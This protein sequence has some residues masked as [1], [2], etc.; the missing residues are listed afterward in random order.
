ME[1]ELTQVQRALAVA[2]S[3]RLKAESKREAAHKA[4]CLAGEACTKAKE[5]NSRLTDERLSL[6][7]ELGTIKDDFAAL[8]E[9]VVANR[10]TMEV[11]F[12]A[13]GD[14]LFNYGYGC[15]VFTHNICGRKP[16]IPN[17]MPDPSVLLTPE[18]FANPRC[19]PITSSIAPAP[20][21]ATVSREES[22][23]TARPSPERRR[24][25][26]WVSRLRRTARLRMPL[27]IMTLVLCEAR[28]ELFSVSALKN[29]H[30]F[31]FLHYFLFDASLYVLMLRRLGLYGFLLST[32]FELACGR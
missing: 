13:R 15:C 25:F 1:S 16:Q 20:D 27:L 10:E 26:R 6:I 4:L 19:P 29:L 22:P 9:K 14:T 21:P 32:P 5:E 11:E 28:L 8:R 30:P 7:L 2:E 24:L 31:L 18:F 3:T 23:R 17:G 12:D